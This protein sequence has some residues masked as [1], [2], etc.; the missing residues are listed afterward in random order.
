MFKRDEIIV[1]LGAGAS[2]EAGVPD[3]N[4]M[5]NKIE[6]MVEEDSNWTRYRDLYRYLRSAVFFA[7]GLDGRFGDDVSFNIERL[8]NVL[9]ELYKRERHT[10]YPF[11]GAWNPKLLDVA[12]RQFENISAF[13]DAIIGIL[14]KDWIELPERESANYYKGVLR[15]QEEY[16]HSLRVFSLNYDLCVEEACG[17]DNVQRGFQE[18]RWDWRLFEEDGGDPARILLYKLHGSTDWYF[19]EDG[20]IKYSDSRSTIEDRKVALI[21]GTEYKL[22]YVDPF[23]FLAYQL[24]RW[25]LDSARVIVCVGYGF[26]DDHIN[27]ILEQALRQDET[28]KVLTV[29]GPG[30]EADA[31]ARRMRTIRRLRAC[32]GQ[33]VSRTCGAKEFLEKELTVARLGELFPTES[34]LIPEL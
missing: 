30:G 7:D 4:S 20:S 15:L 13:R 11:V 16:G 1:L 14:R 27:G 25:T 34:D 9:Q 5:V 19:A 23:L 10:V 21:F 6:R 8:V 26:N 3:S 18:R 29:N 33:V 17:M 22:Q 24:R 28:R 12:G 32:D 31:E 2:V